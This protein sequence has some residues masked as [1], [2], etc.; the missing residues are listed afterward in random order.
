MNA[1]ATRDWMSGN[2]VVLRIANELEGTRGH[3]A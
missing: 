3:P 2:A 1:R